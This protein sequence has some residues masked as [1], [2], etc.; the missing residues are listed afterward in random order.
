MDRLSSGQGWDVGRR[1]PRTTRRSYGRI[2]LLE[3]GRMW[4]LVFFSMCVIAYDDGCFTLPCEYSGHLNADV[5]ENRAIYVQVCRPFC[6]EAYRTGARDGRNTAK[7]EDLARHLCK[8]P[9][10]RLGNR[11]VLSNYGSKT[12]VFV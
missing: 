11:A 1:F 2:E 4:K 7:F 10:V 6:K 5:F 3:D 9:R 12:T 8:C